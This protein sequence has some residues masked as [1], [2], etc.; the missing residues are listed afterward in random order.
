MGMPVTI[1][2]VDGDDWQESMDLAFRFLEHVDQTFSTY[3]KDSE[4]SRINRGDL[5]SR[6]YSEEMREILKLSEET[7]EQTLGYFNIKQ[8]DGSLDP[9]GVVKGW[10]IQKSAA[11]IYSR[12]HKNFYVEAGGDIQSAGVNKRGE[13]WSVGIRNPFKKDEIVKVI[14]PKGRGVAT[15]GTYIRGE[16]IYDPYTGR[17]VKTDYVSFTVIGP[18]VYEADRVATAAFAMGKKGAG[19]IELL[20]EFEGYFITQDGKAEMTSGFHKYASHA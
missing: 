10:A 19:F 2:I 3:K 14:N 16:H 17:P 8:P 18:N 1:E 9:S 6:D 15:S 11:L 20:P 13:G 12:G 7:R 4:I 5:S